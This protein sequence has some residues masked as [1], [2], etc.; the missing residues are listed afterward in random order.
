MSNKPNRIPRVLS[1]QSHVVHGYVGNKCATFILQL[2]G[3]EVDIINSVHFSNHTGYNV[4]KGSRLTADELRSIFEGLMANELFDYDYI[5]TGYM[6]SGELLRVV[7]EYVRLI[8][9]K[10]PHVKYLCDPVIGDNGKLYVDQSCVDV[11]KNII[12]PLADIVTPNDFELEQLIGRKIE[13]SDNN[14][15]QIIWQ[16]LQSLHSM[17][18]S[19]I[20]MSSILATNTDGQKSQLQMYASSKSSDN[21]YETF[22]IDFPYLK[23]CFT[24]TGDSFSALILA[25]FHRE[26]NLISACEKSISILHQ[27]LLNTIELSQSVNTHNTLGNELNLIESRTAIE[28]AKILFHAVRTDTK[29]DIN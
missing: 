8:K 28:A 29:K 4:V 22:R 21:Q 20:I 15:E 6:G 3:F 9:S 27:I 5:L 1:I 7:A 23:G 25:W 10:S 13:C 11:Y 2:Y 24:G 26:G 18:P 14:K 19:H 17:G 12:L 16:S